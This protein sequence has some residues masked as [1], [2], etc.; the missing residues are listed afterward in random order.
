[1]TS[2]NTLALL[3]QVS[4][5]VVRRQPF[6]AV[7]NSLAAGFESAF[8]QLSL[9][10]W[11]LD[12]SRKE[13]GVRLA[14][15][16]IL[17]DADWNQ[18]KDQFQRHLTG[19]AAQTVDG[20]EQPEL[21]NW[22][23]EE[24]P[25]RLL[26]IRVGD[27]VAGA[28]TVHSPRANG[29]APD[30]WLVLTMLADELGQALGQEQLLA[31]LQ[32]R[33]DQLSVL[34]RITETAGGLKPLK[35]AL[36]A[37]HQLLVDAFKVQTC[38]IGLHDAVTGTVSFPF[39]THKGQPVEIPAIQVS[40]PDSLVGWVVRNNQPFIADDWPRDGGPVEGITHWD[41]PGS[42]LCHPMRVADE[43]VGVLSIQ[44]SE[45]HTFDE[46]DKQLLAVIA[47]HI[48][49]IV[50]NAK[51]YTKTNALVERSVDQWRTAE[52]L[53]KAAAA[54]GSSLDQA[55]VL[56]ELLLALNE[57]VPY[58]S[59]AIALLDE[60]E[61][62]IKAHHGFADEY[63][64]AEE[65]HRDLQSSPILQELVEKKRT[66]LLNDVN[67]DP[68][69]VVIKGTESV[70]S[71]L[72]APLLVGDEVIGALM[73]D[74]SRPDAYGGRESW[75]VSVL[76]S[77][78]AVAV[79]N[80]RL[81]HEVQ[82]QV[83]ELTTLYEA[84]AAM[85]AD[86]DQATVYENVVRIMVRAF[87]VDL[88][89]IFAWDG[90]GR[91]F[92]HVSSKK[93]IDGQGTLA[94][95]FSLETIPFLGQLLA[96]SEPRAVQVDGKGGDL[97][98]QTGQAI[99]SV[100]GVPSALL[101][102]VRWRENL[103][104]LL[105]LGSA[106]H[107]RKFSS[108]EMQRAR[109][110]TRQAAVAIEHAHLFAQSQRR[111]EE[112][113]AFHEIALQLN[114]PLELSAVL[115]VITESALKLIAANNVHI[116]LYDADRDEFTFGSALSRDGNRRPAVE[117]PRS[118]GITAAIIRTAEA[119]IIGD[120]GR[121]P[122][123]QSPEAAAWGIGAI[124]GFPLRRGE[125]VF[126]AFT[127]T[128]LDPHTFTDD[129]LLLLNLLADQ[130]AVAVEN[131]RL[132]TDAQRRLR[133]MSALVD[134]A[135]QVTGNLKVELVME[136]TV[137]ILRD[138]LNARA[139]SIAL[140]E[141]E[142][143]EL[144][145][146]AAAGI[147]RKWLHRARMQVGEGVSGQ[148]VKERRAIYIQD[149]LAQPDFLFFDEVLRSLISV[150]LISRDEVIGA[151]TV[152]SDR[153]N[154]F[155]ES[156]IQLMTIAGAQ[157]STAIANARLF[158]EAEDR[159]AKL[160]VAYEELKE[161]DRL[162]DELVQNVSHELR[163]PLTFVKGYVD[164][165][166]DGEMG[167][168]NL[169]Q[170]QTL[171]I[172]ADKTVEITRLI[173]DIMSLQRVDNSNLVLEQFAMAQLID[174]TVSGHRLSAY[175][176]GLAIRFDTPDS[177]GVVVADRGRVAQVLNNI[178]VNAMKFSPDG[179]EIMVEMIDEPSEVT[180]V[181]TD[182]GIGVPSNKVEKIFER[183]YQVDGTSRRRFGGAGIGLAIVKRIIDAHGGR[184]WVKSQVNHGSSFY[185]S[186]PK[187]PV[188]QAPERRSVF[189]DL[190]D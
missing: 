188:L 52:A 135:Q 47:D 16:E 136:T 107:S 22:G 124:A 48:A 38:Y 178:I 184:I 34:H 138:L 58:D 84:T 159:A 60:G 161:N 112:L 28:L 157:V 46:H 92:Q 155:S 179:G 169:D 81:H 15:G 106:S 126:G 123:F 31:E 33:T 35:P 93:R 183:F 148:A 146:E 64:V 132:F 154:A 36:G 156:D 42:L 37:I 73:V 79:Q 166:M 43:V 86:L 77:H 51:L 164:L 63:A 108:Q 90:V 76:A 18:L 80:A 180:I 95:S 175:Q 99:L 55:A 137:Q 142:T 134:M 170:Q 8:P 29:I 61:V 70:R 11:V 54:V 44:S 21:R 111:V 168:I 27:S 139:S 141:V 171:Q 14:L 59:A 72:G 12:G 118:N 65:A 190:S 172:V 89:A 50:K 165:L 4:E 103:L 39:A 45:S 10:V 162:K 105:V 189:G 1:M 145:V 160:A 133:D 140:L 116:F 94:S 114:T 24:G 127:L 102:P 30:E 74:S 75:L 181:I 68:R 19:Q 69:W 130:A 32:L 62:V 56:D 104:G 26:P 163:T 53:R 182:Q 57:V 120:A 119:H 40:R 158:E 151:L 167:L 149:T 101:V 147:D 3:G 173:D 9:Q 83:S 7:V 13:L 91:R 97:G 150:P 177:G 115:D 82:R 122:F 87:E 109:N 143:Q 187:Q 71:W 96:G 144:I 100:L 113:S 78:A 20:G 2:A 152:D 66:I 85:T 6:A 110:L 185:C 121:H 128:Y 25:W 174:D 129:E 131:A 176:K 125:R 49:V 41:V 17:T 5:Q 153:P 23:V 67:D 117:K 88:C 186:F 98:D